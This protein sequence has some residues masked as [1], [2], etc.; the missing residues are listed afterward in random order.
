MNDSLQDCLIIIHVDVIIDI[1]V[2]VII[3][4]H[5]DVNNHIEWSTI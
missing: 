1:H 3:D 2:N 5:V 4:I